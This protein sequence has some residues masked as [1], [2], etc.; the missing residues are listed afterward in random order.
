MGI[1][2]FKPW[3][4]YYEMAHKWRGQVIDY[5]ISMEQS[6]EIFIT[7]QFIR[8]ET[9]DEYNKKSS[10]FKRLLLWDTNMG[11]ARKKQIT[12]ALIDNYEPEF[13]LIHPDVDPELQ[14]VIECR[15]ALAHWQLDLGR[16]YRWFGAKNKEMKVNKLNDKNTIII[17]EPYIKEI[18][19]LARKYM[20]V[21][22]H[23]Q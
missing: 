8:A 11:L 20:N 21:F 22:Y 23:W 1:N 14:K 13:K 3:E 6:I 4:D 17:T 15:N 9:E 2:P 7:R 18:V 10:D 19:E 16:E 12:I 5:T